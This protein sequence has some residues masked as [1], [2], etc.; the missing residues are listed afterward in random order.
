MKVLFLKAHHCGPT[1]LLHLFLFSY[2]V[3]AFIL[4]GIKTHD[5]LLQTVPWGLN[6]VN[7]EFKFQFKTIYKYITV[8][9]G[10]F[11]YYCVN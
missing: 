4:D 1:N 11:A 2:T 5:L 10:T 6:I 7:F 9:V 3:I 8:H